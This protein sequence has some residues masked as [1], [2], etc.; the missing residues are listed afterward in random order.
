VV[1]ASGGYPQDYEKGKEISGLQQAQKLTDTVVFHA[2]TK[3]EDD[4]YFTSGGRVLNVVSLGDD[5]EKAKSRA[6]RAI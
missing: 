6:Y 5:L 3:K 1:I 4:K 2:G